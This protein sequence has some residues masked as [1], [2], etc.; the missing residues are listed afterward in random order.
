[1]NAVQIDLIGNHLK[2]RL[3]AVLIDPEGPNGILTSSRSRVSE[4]GNPSDRARNGPVGGIF[5][6]PSSEISRLTPPERA[7]SPIAARSPASA[8]PDRR[9][10]VA[11]AIDF[12]H[13]AGRADL[14]APVPPPSPGA[15]RAQAFHAWL[16][17]I[18][19]VHGPGPG[20]WYDAGRRL[21]QAMAVLAGLSSGALLA[22]GLLARGGDEPVNAL[23]FFGATVGLQ[24]A[25]LVIAAIAWAWRGRL[26]PGGLQRALLVLVGIGARLLARLDGHRRATL[27]AD[28]AALAIRSSRLAPLVARHLLL[29]TQSFAIAFNAG[30]IAA[31][32]L[33]WLP[34]VEWRFGWQSTYAFTAEG[35]HAFVRAVAIPWHWIA[36]GLAPTAAD[37]AA[38]RYGRGQSATTLPAAAGHAWWPF[39]VAAI[40]CYGFALRAVLALLVALD[41]RRRLDHLRFDH[42]EANALWRRLTGPAI[43]SGDAGPVLENPSIPARAGSVGID[44][45]VRDAEAPDDPG[46]PASIAR[47]FGATPDVIV[48]AA[49][50]DDALDAGLR[51]A[52]ARRPTPRVAVVVS[53]SRDPIVAIA[54]FLRAVAA[55]SGD[56]A[57]LTLVLAGAPSTA[58]ADVWR[59]FVGLQ[60]L[61]FDVET[62]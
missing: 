31:M 59:R 41:L 39:L 1:M 14:A 6:G 47:I 22:G 56:G 32:L 62:A 3:S 35:V 30:L 57:A 28:G 25:V 53:A 46:L 54:D 8:G 49:I 4:T 50:D 10:T 5:R 52:L 17:A 37:I 45:V 55:A 9:W 34:F 51:E 12:E 18:R 58:R 38:S 24:S 19:A 20:R 48:A 11:D 16:E 23:L 44:V 29:V 36:D 7:R 21:L 26:A 15:S 61:P 13:F 42:P 2:I 33:V 40:A 43:R 27:R 60:R